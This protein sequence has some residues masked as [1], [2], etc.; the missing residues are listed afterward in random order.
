MNLFFIN[1]FYS[2]SYAIHSKPNCILYSNTVVISMPLY[3][4]QYLACVLCDNELK[5]C[6]RV[7]IQYKYSMV[8]KQRA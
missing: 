4:I 3:T 8:I 2:P 6:S 5:T 7:G 1:L